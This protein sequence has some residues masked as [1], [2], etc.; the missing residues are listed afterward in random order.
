M[1]M[2]KKLEGFRLAVGADK[3]DDAS[4]VDRFQ[5]V[6]GAIVTTSFYLTDP[7]FKTMADAYIAAGGAFAGQTGKVKQADLVAGQARTARD[8]G[9]VTIDNAYDALAAGVWTRAASVQDVTNCGFALAQ[10]EPISSVIPMPSAI[11][12]KY[13]VAQGAILLNVKWPTKG[14]HTCYIEVS[15][16]PVGPT[17]WKRLDTTGVKLKLTGYA[18]GTW[19]FHAATSRAK[20]RSDWFG[21]VAVVV[22]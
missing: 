11:L 2:P 18:P 10:V 22:K 5:L 4:R 7:A 8:R 20:A 17:T 16:D 12:L 21:P 3:I 14:K 6:E 1:T 13:D 19:W 9:R 15:P